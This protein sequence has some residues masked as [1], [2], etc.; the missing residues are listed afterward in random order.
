MA[1]WKKVL[2]GLLVLAVLFV[3]FVGPWPTYANSNF[4]NSKYYK[5]ALAAIDANVK[6]TEITATPGR[7]SAGWGA[8]SI[9]PPIGTPLAGFGNR[10]GKPSTGM[11]DEIHVKALALSDGHD[12]IALV[13]SDMLIVPNNVADLARAAAA[14]ETKLTPNDILFNASHSHCGP[15]AWGPGIA[16][17][18]FGGTYDPK[19]VDF[20]AEAFAGAIIDAYKALQP[21][22]AAFGSTDAPQYI[23][24]RE[25]EAGV[26]PELS[27]MLVEQDDG[28]RC[29]LASY[30][31]HPTVLGGGIMEFSADYPG[32]L[33]RYIEKNAK[34]SVVYLG[35]A[36]GSMGPKAPDNPDPFMRAQ[37]MGEALAKL[38]L[39]GTAQPQF[40][41]NLDI[42]A[43]GV[44]ITVP[45]LQVRLN[46]SLRVSPNL[47]NFL[48]IDRGAWIH[49]VRVGKTVF[50][51][52]PCDFSGELSADMKK[53]AQNEGVDLWCLSFCADYIGYISPDK[54]YQDMYEKDGGFAYEVG[55]M[56]WCGPNQGEYFTSLIKHLVQALGKP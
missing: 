17:K 33:Q 48:G 31:A 30:S 16:A 41:T 19:I 3:I 24:N 53:W 10:Q 23:R 2:L 47:V 43:A 56:S 4:E 18:Q 21:A 28:D 45:P 11:H 39:E 13:G 36:V 5:E 1:R 55:Q 27:Y 46:P 42:V 25:R 37:L 7:L 26:D 8:R 6:K 22:K 54:Y 9:V 50:A 32:Y 49:G 35:G 15:G 20:L 29:V 14:K 12:T 38:V 51:G 52:M 40:E 34:S 44:P